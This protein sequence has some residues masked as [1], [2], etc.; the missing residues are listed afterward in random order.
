MG[1]HILYI[2]FIIITKPKGFC[3]DLPKDPDYN[4]EH[5]IGSIIKHNELLVQH[6]I[7]NE[8]RQLLSKYKHKNNI[9]EH[10]KQK[11]K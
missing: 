8:V 5:K 3:F 7:K 1:A 6:T 9:L 10:R 4:L 2:N 11:S